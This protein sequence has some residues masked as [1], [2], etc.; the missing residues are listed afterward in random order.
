MAEPLLLLRLDQQHLWQTL[1]YVEL[2]P[3]RAKLV[4]QAGA[5]RWSSAAAHLA[6]QPAPPWLDQTLWHGSRTAG[7]WRQIL[8]H[9]QDQRLLGQI[10][11]STHRGRPLASDRFL[12]KLEGLLNRRLRP[13]P[14]G[15]PKEAGGCIHRPGQAT[16]LGPNESTIEKSR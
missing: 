16:R 4:R 2:N 7:H 12:A 10:R 3:V 11:L 1:A 8:S 5:Y 13:L 9:K 15:R 14:V 6:Q